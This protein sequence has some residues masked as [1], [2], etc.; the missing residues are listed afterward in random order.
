MWWSISKLLGKW[1]PTDPPSCRLTPFNTQ[2][3]VS[4]DCHYWSYMCGKGKVIRIYYQGQ[5]ILRRR[6]MVLR[7]GYSYSKQKGYGQSQ[8]IKHGSFDHHITHR[9]LA[10]PICNIKLVLHCFKRWKYLYII[11]IYFMQLQLWPMMICEKCGIS[12]MIMLFEYDIFSSQI[13]W[14]FYHSGI[15]FLAQQIWFILWIVF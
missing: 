9:C 5:N 11:T 15:K 7:L 8:D 2:Q 10:M 13:P 4:L 3:W 14:L 6:Y 12:I 1:K